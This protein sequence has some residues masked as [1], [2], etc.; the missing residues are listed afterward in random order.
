MKR[1]YGVYQ[2]GLK[3]LLRKKGHFL[4]LKDETGKY[5]DLPG[6]RIDNV[7]DQV[8][9]EKILAREVREELGSRLRYR[10]IKP[11][12]QYRRF[13]HERRVFLNVFEAE[14]VSGH[15]RLSPEH[16]SYHWID[17]VRAKFRQKDF[18]SKEEYLAFREYF[19]AAPVAKAMNL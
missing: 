4:L 6:G 18:N 15:I 19:K 1:D 7:E 12:F 2:V 16:S 3:I 13:F 14:Y 5:W 10:L 9:L 8:P 11:I 17:P